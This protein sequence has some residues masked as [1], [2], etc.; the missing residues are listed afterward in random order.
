MGAADRIFVQIPAYRD[1][2]LSAT[3]RDLIGKAAA[4]ES[5]RIMVGWQF[6]PGETLDDDV[7]SA[8]QVEIIRIPHQQSRGCN[9][10]RR[11]IQKRWRGEP[12]TLLL[13]SHHRFVPGWDRM[14][15]DMHAS[16]LTRGVR[17]PL[18]TGYLPPYR[19][20]APIDPCSPPMRIY[21]LGRELGVLS[22]LTSYPLPFWRERTA[23][24]PANFLSLHFAFVAGE[25][26]AEAPFDPDIYFFGDETLLGARAFTHGYDL[27]H[28]H[29]VIGWHNYDRG[30]RL[31]HWDD[32][33]L[34]F[35]QH[36]KSLRRIRAIVGGRARG[37]LGLGKQRTIADYED[38]IMMK[39]AEAE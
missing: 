22:K 38:M 36:R 11:T 31:P 18:I 17:K 6:A 35:A 19:P 39:V 15:R 25:F 5:L 3:L 14:L 13:D 10:A 16:L 33:P 21:P 7:V 23:P 20:D 12:F 30:A 32:H 4:P 9:W 29:R 34:W 8:P 2:E 24:V 27:F 37:R 26:N 1:A 28:P